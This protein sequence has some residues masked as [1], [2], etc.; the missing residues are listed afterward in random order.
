MG[1][2]PKV[3]GE[4]HCPLDGRVFGDGIEPLLPHRPD[5]NTSSTVT[6]SSTATGASRTGSIHPS[7]TIT[8]VDG[9]GPTT[10]PNNPDIIISESIVVL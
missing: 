7:P 9:D 10:D 5:P 2:C 8:L 3:E 1:C 6:P 4:V